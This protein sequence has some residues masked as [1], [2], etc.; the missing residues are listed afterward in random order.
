MSSRLWRGVLILAG[1]ALLGAG[2]WSWWSKRQSP[3]ASAPLRLALLPAEN[4]SGDAS[5]DWAAPL[6]PYSL[7]RQF[8]GL[9][10]VSVFAVASRAEAAGLGATHQVELLVTRRGGNAEARFSV[11]SQAPGQLIAQGSASA[12]SGDPPALLAAAS[13]AVAS[14][15]GLR[16]PARPPAFHNPASVREFA[17]ALQRPAEAPAHLEAALAADEACGWCLL[18]WAETSLR[19]G[20]PSRALAVLDRGRPVL[21]KIDP[22]SRTRVQLM[23]A[24]LKSDP[25]QRLAALEQLSALLPADAALQGRLADALVAARQYDRAAASFRLALQAEPGR[26]DLWN[27]L[28][29][30][31][32]YAGKFP[33]ARQA[34]ARYSELDSS[35]PNP[36]D[37]SGEVAMLAGDFASAARALVQAY[38]KDKNFND[39]SSLE[40]AALAHYL[41]GERDA[42]GPLLE[43]YLTDR[44]QRG[45]PL[46]GL[47]RARWDDL[48]GQTAQSR[49]LLSSLAAD[50]RNPMASMAAS[51]LALRQAAD[52][53]PAAAARSAAS[54]RAL[55]RNPGQ[56]YI[57]VFAAAV[58]NPAAASALPDPA[59]RADARA[60]GLT[61]RGEWAAGAAAWKEALSLAKGGAD[62]P[63]RELQALCLVASGRA[64]EA[65]GLVSGSWPLLT[66]EQA[67]LYDFL[68]YPNLLYVRAEVARAAN[69]G[70]EAQRLYDLFLQYAGDRPDRA[71]RLARARA[72]S[73]L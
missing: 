20:G 8:E 15:L 33:E 29:Y 22:V 19:S 54:A 46:A 28:A 31:T 16:A 57:A 2:A 5:L 6:L 45:D 64:A 65:A 70:A 24:E 51:L 43:R 30:A 40:K 36:L 4:Q 59:W 32:A 63:Q 1:I 72:A 37:S 34:L 73:R 60:L 11:Y 10:R 61:L 52:G 23:E 62:A 3:A 50:T 44:T 53:D 17:A 71:G 58:L 27:S 14:A 35:S 13:Q 56:A 25:R 66:R 48:A 9:P 42:V 55:A 18:A 41:G 49:A 69:R 21:P 26:A 38:E 39:G 47:A 7:A 12:P 67:L 68:V